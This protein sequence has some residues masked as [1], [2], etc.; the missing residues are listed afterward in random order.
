[1]GLL[2][3]ITET[4][5]DAITTRSPAYRGLESKLKEATEQLSVFDI[6]D[7]RYWQAVG[8]SQ[9]DLPSDVRDTI[10]RQTWLTYQTIPTASGFVN[11]IL[12]FMVGPGFQITHPD[13]RADKVV[14]EYIARDRFMALSSEVLTQYLITAEVPAQ[15]FIDMITGDGLVRAFDPLELYDVIYDVNDNRNV[16]GLRRRYTRREFSFEAK[17]WAETSVED[18][19][20]HDER[21][22][23]EWGAYT[24]RDFVFWKRPTMPSAGRGLPFLTP[25]LKW[26]TQYEKLLEA[27]LVL[28]RA[29]ATYARDLDMGPEATQETCAKRQ[30]ELDAEGERRPG[31]WFV[32]NT[33]TKL[34]FPGPN[35]GAGDARDD[36]RAFVLM[37]VAGLGVPE[38]IATGDASNGNF[39][40][41]TNVVQAFVKGIQK[42]QTDFTDGWVDPVFKRLLRAKAEARQ[43]PAEAAEIPV[44]V[45]CPEILPFELDKLGQVLQWA[46]ALDVMSKEDALNILPWDLTR[47]A[48]KERIAAEREERMEKA[49]GVPAEHPNEKDTVKL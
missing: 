42:F 13:E 28:N 2:T 45:A 43:I 44:N 19:I 25:V 31:A 48:V 7:P 36:L 39:A 10:S 6:L 46:V 3:R 4:F 40:S 32:H 24:V 1:M 37:I 12:N 35:I 17:A 21:R 15:L 9:R 49:G 11:N 16:L 14:Q 22:P 30:A 26:M 33:N 18:D 47:D 27:R 29:R 34:T 23:D 5:A 20:Q 41:T 38:F 8:S